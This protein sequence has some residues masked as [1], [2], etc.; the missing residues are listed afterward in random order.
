MEK[1]LLAIP[2]L[3]PTHNELRSRET[4]DYFVEQIRAGVKS[5]PVILTRFEDGKIYV[6]DGHHR[7]CAMLNCGIYYLDEV[8]YK[9][10]DRTYSDYIYPAPQNGWFTPF[11]PKTQCRLSDFS[12]IKNLFRETY[13]VL[14]FEQLLD[15]YCDYFGNKPY[16]NMW[17]EER[18]IQTLEELYCGMEKAWGIVDNSHPA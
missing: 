15:L 1:K 3:I 11:N 16:E 12:R 7:L 9:I 5:S 10:A 18:K 4:F 2:T 14:G 6:H 13:E 8:E 17:A